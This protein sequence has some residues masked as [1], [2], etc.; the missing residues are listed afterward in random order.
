MIYPQVS[1]I[2]PEICPDIR[3]RPTYSPAGMARAFGLDHAFA[4]ARFVRRSKSVLIGL[5][6]AGGVAP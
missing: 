1:L 3:A 5:S 4:Q 6:G 2:Y